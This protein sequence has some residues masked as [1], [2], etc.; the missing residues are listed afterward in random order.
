MGTRGGGEDSW[1]PA[2]I[3]RTANIA[4]HQSNRRVKPSMEVF[5]IVARPC[6]RPGADR[7]LFRHAWGSKDWLPPH[8]VRVRV[9]KSLW[10]HLPWR[11]GCLGWGWVVW[12]GGGVR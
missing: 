4:Q 6:G 3:V 5:R 8:L 10:Q 2:R 11:A 9:S 1:H 7:R 12:G